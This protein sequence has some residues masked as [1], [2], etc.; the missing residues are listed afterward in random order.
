MLLADVV[1][2]QEEVEL[3]VMDGMAVVAV[4]LVMLVDNH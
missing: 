4:H 3:V 2:F 1:K